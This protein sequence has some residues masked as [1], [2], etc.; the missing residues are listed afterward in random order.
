MLTA[1]YLHIPFCNQIC[2][3]CDFHKEIATISKKTAYINALCQEIRNNQSSYQNIKTIYIGGGT[4]S[5]LPIPLLEKLLM[6]IH[7]YVKIENVLEFSIETNPN[8]IDQELVDLF[9]KYG[10]TRVSLGVQT[11]NQ[12]HLDFLGRTH[13]KEDVDH[14]IKILINSGIKNI[15]VDMI[16]SLVNQSIEELEEDLLE[17]KKLSI[18]HVSYYSL[19][20]EEKTKLYYLYEQNK[21]SMNSEDLE[22]LMYNKVIDT[23]INMGYQHYEISNFCKPGFQSMH[24]I[25]YWKTEDYLGMGSGSHSLINGTRYFQIANITKYVQ[26]IMT[27]SDDKTFYDVEPLR[28]ALIMGLRLIDGIN[29][30]DINKRYNIDLLLMY[31]KINDFIKDELLKIQEGHLSFTRKGLLLGNVIF[32]IF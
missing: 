28:E 20:F 29:I 11:F 10:I 15:N 17:L 32:G 5:S 27:N 3:Y 1:L 9:V 13:S 26:S 14:A 12:K 24:N 25:I 6:T 16:F 2:V 19:I 8:D 4:P 30:E 18:Q 31:P 23:M 7:E 21:V 22:A